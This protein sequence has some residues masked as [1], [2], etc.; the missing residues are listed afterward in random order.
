MRKERETKKDLNP[1]SG[2]TDGG[3]TNTAPFSITELDFLKNHR[4][5][6]TDAQKEGFAS[7][8]LLVREIMGTDTIGDLR[9]LMG[10]LCKIS[11]NSFT[12]CDGELLD[13]GVGLYPQ[14]S[15]LNHSCW[16]NCSSIFNGVMLEIRNIRNISKDEEIAISYSESMLPTMQRRQE[17]NE[18]YFFTCTC[19]LCNWRQNMCTDVKKLMSPA[20]ERDLLVTA[21]RCNNQYCGSPVFLTN[22]SIDT[23]QY[24]YVYMHVYTIYFF[25]FGNS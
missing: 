24:K 17:L 15:V 13:L 22:L 25:Y 18:R 21:L 3:L 20:Y 6:Y 16:P 11:C 23:K 10:L 8:V 12:I 19:F 7:I 4:E 9:D 2:S 1:R 14:L 5:K